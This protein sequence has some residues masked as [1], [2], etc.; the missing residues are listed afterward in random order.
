M[1]TKPIPANINVSGYPTISSLLGSIVS[2]T[3]LVASIVEM[4]D[5]CDVEP[6]DAGEGLFVLSRLNGLIAQLQIELG[7]IADDEFWPVV[8]PK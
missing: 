4:T 7:K 2:Q 8:S 6:D 3:R 1:K 5:G